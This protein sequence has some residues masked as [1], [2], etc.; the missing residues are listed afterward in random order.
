MP[1]GVRVMRTEHRGP[2]KNICVGYDILDPTPWEESADCVVLYRCPICEKAV[3]AGD[4]VY[5]TEDARYVLH[6]SC[7]V[8]RR[9]DMSVSEVLDRLGMELYPAVADEEL[10]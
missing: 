3:Y 7:A 2:A 10:R 9:V 1:A 4:R 6:E 8:F 5:V